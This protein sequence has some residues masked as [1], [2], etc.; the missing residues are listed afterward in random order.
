MV[1]TDTLEYNPL[2][3]LLLVNPEPKKV[4]KPFF[5]LLPSNNIQNKNPPVSNF[6]VPPNSKAESHII[7]KK[8]QPIKLETTDSKCLILLS[9]KNRIFYIIFRN[10]FD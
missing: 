6:P 8:F 2:D 7:P 5:S 10:I 9:I 1:N 4:I 3:S